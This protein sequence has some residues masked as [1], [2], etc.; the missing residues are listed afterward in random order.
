MRG[1]LQLSA[2][3]TLTWRDGDRVLLFG[4]PF[5]QAGD[6]R[7]P[8]STARITTIVTSEY[9]S[10]KLGVRG[11][12]VGLV[13]QDR[14][15]AVAGVLGPRAR[16]LPLEVRVEGALAAA[17]HFHFEMVEDRTL[18]PQ[19]AGLATLNSLLESGGTGASQTVEWSIGLHRPGV[20]PL[21]LRDEATGDGLLAEMA[22]AISGPLGF[23]FANPFER[24]QLDSVVVAVRVRPGREQWTLR[25]ARLLDAS[26]RPGG[27][28]R[29]ACLVERWRGGT[30]T[31]VLE[32]PVA[33][34]LP[35]GRY[36]L[37]VGGGAE[38]SRIEATRFPARFR[39]TS[40]EDAWR[41]FARLRPSDGLYAAILANA[42]D[43]T[44]DGRDYPELPS[45]AAAVLSSGLTAGDRARR[46]DAALTGETRLPLEG[47]TRGELQLVLTVDSK[48]P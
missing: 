3:G 4:H 10:F 43:V 16:L 12:E 9:L 17:R 30:E 24:L 13:T 46:A 26:V 35:D 27:S 14:Q 38:L 18:A 19:L 44:A 34:Q 25:S 8:L 33:R 28:A 41:R 15:S 22:S 31:R 45:S 20:A 40:L 21:V 37:W 47:L 1:D 29:L 2:I 32:V 6:V 11:R 39:P 23:L 7:L 48:A 36:N 5:F 42:P